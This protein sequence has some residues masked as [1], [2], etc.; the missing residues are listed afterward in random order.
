MK[1]LQIALL[2]FLIVMAANLGFKYYGQSEK[3]EDTLTED[4][5]SLIMESYKLGY[6][7]GMVTTYKT[8][9]YEEALLKFKSDSIAHRNLILK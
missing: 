6:V 4:Q 9:S 5:L 3:Q 2:I 7:T 8:K 1:S